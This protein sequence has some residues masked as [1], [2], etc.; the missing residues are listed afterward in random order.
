MW[1]A[2]PGSQPVNPGGPGKIAGRQFVTGGAS[3]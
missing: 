1:N 2:G 3:S